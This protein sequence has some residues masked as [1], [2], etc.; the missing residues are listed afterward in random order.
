MQKIKGRFT[1]ATVFSDTAESYAIAQVQMICDNEAAAGSKIRIMPDVHPGKVAP[2]GLSMTVG[3][4][5]MPNLVG[6]DIGCGITYIRIR[7]TKIEYQRLDKV[8]REHIPS[9]AGVRRE[10]HLHSRD[11]DFSNLLCKK[12][13]N[14]KKAELSLGTLGGGNHFIELCKDKDENIYASVHTG[15]RSLGKEVTDFY[16]KKGHKLLKEKGIVVPYE[17]TYLEGKLMEEYLHDVSEV[18]GYAML[19]REI[20]LRELAKHTKWK[21][22]KYGESIHNYVDENRV[23]RKGAVSAYKEDEVIIPVNMKDGIIIA[24]GKGNPLWNYSAPHR[25]GR[26]MSREEVRKTHTVSEFKRQVQGI[27]STTVNAETL[28]EAP[29]AYRGID[30]IVE[31]IKD[32]VEVKKILKPIYNYKA[33]ERR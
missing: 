3:S 21:V 19:N 32:T 33:G 8:I 14:E 25:G 7:K 31:A 17:L 2:I 9:G 20:I 26:I 30:E 6:S 4:K 5:V 12:H 13:V 28:D 16:V 15:S 11:F 24:E 29:F 10:Q 18:Q 23:L 27:Y 22:E 1:S